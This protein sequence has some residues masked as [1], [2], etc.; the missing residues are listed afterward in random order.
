[1]L[2]H[3]AD[4]LG[5]RRALRPRRATAGASAE[6]S[7]CAIL[8]GVPEDLAARRTTTRARTIARGA[9]ARTAAVATRSPNIIAGGSAQESGTNVGAARW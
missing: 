9:P 8:A 4:E 2:A 3:S 6:P 7:C 1:M 5:V